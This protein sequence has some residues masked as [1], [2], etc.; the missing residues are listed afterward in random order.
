MLE[1]ILEFIANHWVLSSIWAILLL[2]L[3]KTESGRGGSSISN[4]EATQLINK[5]DA[6]IIDLR[7]RDDFQSGHLPNAINIPAKDM[8]TRMSELSAYKDEHLI[9]VCKTGTTASAS[10]TVLAKEGFNKL[11]KL[12]GGMMDWKANN[13]PVVK[14]K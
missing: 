12:K 8:Q 11:H 2:L 6:K 13:L 10:G 5:Q 1:Q 14:G 7:N 3:L 9:L 4:Q